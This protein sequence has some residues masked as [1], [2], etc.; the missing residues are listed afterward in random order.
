MELPW[1][2]L[3]TVPAGLKSRSSHLAE[4]VFASQT[5]HLLYWPLHNPVIS[6]PQ[7][8]SVEAACHM[9]VRVKQM[10]SKLPKNTV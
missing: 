2:D 6:A 3:K 1:E 8:V 4:Y 5:L 10:T 7:I 9:I